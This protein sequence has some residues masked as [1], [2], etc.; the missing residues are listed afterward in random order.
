MANVFNYVDWLADES[1]RLLLNKLQVTEF[2]NTDYNS[3][4]TKAFAVGETVRVNFPQQFTTRDGMAYNPQPINRRNTTVTC[5]QFFGVDFEWDSFEQALKMERGMEKIKREYIEPAMAN[6]AQEWD[7]RAALFAYQNAN[8][9]VGVLGTDPTAFSTINQA[10]QRM[11]E[12]GGWMQGTKRGLI[13]PP[14]VN[15]SLVNAAVSYFNPASAISKQYKEGAIGT[16]SGFEWYESMSLWSHTAGTIA[17]TITLNTSSV[18]GATSL[19]VNCTNGDTFKKGDV[20][21]L[22]TIYAVNPMTRRTTTTATT[23]TVVVTEDVTASG[24]TATLPISPTLY[25]PGSQYQNVSALPTSGITLT[26]FP[27]TSSPSAKAGTQGLAINRDAF[28][29]V[30]VE[31]EKVTQAEVY[32]QRRDPDT[33]MAIRFVRM[34]DPQQSKMINRFDTLGG[35]GRLYSD[36]CAVRLLCA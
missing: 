13:I 31:L 7:T 23:K 22:G 20:Y 32:F 10:R 11:V 4:F 27:G 35:F 36:N 18:D 5:D 21:G 30:G 25:G 16:N 14:A 17:G 34:F 26:L 1:L 24:T 9:I 12:L 29:I 2:F 19:V 6:L 28:A 15:T 3:D 8:N 33:G